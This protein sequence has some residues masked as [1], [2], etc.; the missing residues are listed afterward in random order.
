MRFPTRS[1]RAPRSHRRP[2]TPGLETL[3]RRDCPSAFTQL[4]IDEAQLAH[5][6]ASVNA[7]VAVGPQTN[8]AIRQEVHTII[9]DTRAVVGDV[10]QIVGVS[11][12]DLQALGQDLVAYFEAVSHGESVGPAGSVSGPNA[13]ADLVKVELDL[14]AVIASL[15]T[16]TVNKTQ[17]HA[18]ARQVFAALDALYPDEANH[19]LSATR[20]DTQAEVA[21]VGAVIQDLIA[22]H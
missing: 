20:Q 2:V 10:G 4:P 9:R 12:P 11:P 22:G 18:D 19:N 16:S 1:P 21:A 15:A 13:A 6:L 5:D 17:L 14:G 7:A 8:A 3:E